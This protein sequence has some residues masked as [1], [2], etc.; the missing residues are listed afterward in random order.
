[1][2][3]PAD[4]TFVPHFRLSAVLG[5]HPGMPP[6]SVTLC[7]PLPSPHSSAGKARDVR[8]SSKDL[9]DQTWPS[10]SPASGHPGRVVVR[11]LPTPSNCARRRD[12]RGHGVSLRSGCA[13]PRIPRGREGDV[14]RNQWR[15]TQ[16]VVTSHRGPCLPRSRAP[17]FLSPLPLEQPP[18]RTP[19]Q[20]A[21]ALTWP[22]SE[23][24]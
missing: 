22:D 16:A 23:P 9:R 5:T 8:S 18:S 11:G 4:R 24:P 19:R 7:S 3:E 12:M 13:T 20:V 21:M 10:Q 17:A 1:M 15:K 14:Q 2:G 6:F